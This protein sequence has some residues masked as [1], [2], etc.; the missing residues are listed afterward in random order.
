M[1]LHSRG[2]DV[3]RVKGLLDVG[4]PGPVVLDGVQHVVHRPRHLA[5]WP[6]AD[7]RTA[8]SSSPAGSS[9]TRCWRRWRRSWGWARRCRGRRLRR[10]L[11]PVGGSRRSR[12]ARRGGGERGARALAPARG[13]SRAADDRDVDSPHA[14]RRNDVSIRASVRRRRSPRVPG[15]GELKAT[16]GTSAPYC[17][18]DFPRFEHRSVRADRREG[19]ADH[20]SPQPPSP[21]APPAAPAGRSA[22]PRARPRPAPTSITATA[23]RG[24][25][26]GRRRRT[27]R[28]CSSGSAGRRRWT[29]SAVPV[30]PAT[31][32]PGIARPCPSAL[33]DADHHRAH[34]RGDVGA[35]RAVADHRV[36]ADDPRARADALLGDRRADARPSPAAWRG[37][38]PGRSRRRRRPASRSAAL[39]DRLGFAAGMRIRSLKPKRSA[40]ATSRRAPS[41]APSGAKTELH[42]TANGWQRPAARLVAR[43]AQLDARQ[44]RGADRIRARR[45]GDPV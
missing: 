5:A 33:D 13:G 40:A 28:R 11:G 44:R 9:A 31:V 39:G 43:V 6:D 18:G 19:P 36:A 29:S 41:F 17:G 21:T 8:S 34:L 42:D 7:H 10:P 16:R 45:L 12:T 30:L 22:P 1:L 14:W 2:L 24:L 35:D 26:P 20:P 27:R 15:G 23:S 3:L 38:G 37:R 32:T 4:E 25:P